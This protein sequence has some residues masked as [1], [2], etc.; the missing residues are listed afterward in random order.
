MRALIIC[1]TLIMTSYG[2]K[3]QK[4]ITGSYIG[5]QYTKTKNASFI[6]RQLFF[7]NNNDTLILNVKLPFDREKATVQYFG[8]FYNCHL[9]EDTVY[10]ITLQKICADSI[11]DTPNSYY[12]TNTVPNNE[13]C[14][15]FTEVEKNT[16]YKYEGNY[17]MYV[18][19]KGTLYEIIKL[20]P[21]DGCVFPP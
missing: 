8:I 9:K 4:Q 12:I 16:V 11:K 20:T 1:V 6:N 7:L 19:M 18:D 17:G 21:D 3:A 14:S 2:C 5:Y 13:D 10:T 15:K